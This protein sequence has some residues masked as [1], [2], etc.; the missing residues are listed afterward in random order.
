MLA[1]TTEQWVAVSFLP[2]ILGYV[3]FIAVEHF[4]LKRKKENDAS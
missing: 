1:F 3:L 4:W 2:L